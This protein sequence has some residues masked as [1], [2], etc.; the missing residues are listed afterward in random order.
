MA[1]GA[2][3]LALVLLLIAISRLGHDEATLLERA[4]RAGE[5]VV[6]GPAPPESSDATR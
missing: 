3:V 1:L 2:E 4:R 6:A 5:S